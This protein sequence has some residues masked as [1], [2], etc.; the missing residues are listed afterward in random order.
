MTG[1]DVQWDGG[2]GGGSGGGGGGTHIRINT[3]LN[4]ISGSPTA[5]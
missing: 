4:I 5:V 2:G 1:S 3:L